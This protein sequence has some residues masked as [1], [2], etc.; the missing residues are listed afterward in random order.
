MHGNLCVAAHT[1]HPT[2]WE[3]E[4]THHAAHWEPESFCVTGAD[5]AFFI[6]IINRG[7]QPL[8]CGC[9]SGHQ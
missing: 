1:G 4:W 2:Q 3:L 5:I 9:N 8:K 7:T 6:D